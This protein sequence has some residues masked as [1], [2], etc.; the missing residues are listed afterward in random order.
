MTRNRKNAGIAIGCLVAGLALIAVE[1]QDA[2]ME[3]ADAASQQYAIKQRR[4]EAAE[5]RQEVRDLIAQ[6]REMRGGEDGPSFSELAKQNKERRERSAQISVNA[7]RQTRISKYREV[8]WVH[9]VGAGWVLKAEKF[10][11][12][13]HVTMTAETS[14]GYQVSP[15]DTLRDFVAVFYMQFKEREP[16]AHTVKLFNPGGQEIGKFSQLWGYHCEG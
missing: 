2:Q 6:G 3:L 16:T 5:R 13:L 11:E 4:A 7:E 8:A 9:E 15:C 12:T 10:G 14:R 1:R